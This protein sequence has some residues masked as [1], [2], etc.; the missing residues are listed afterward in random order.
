MSILRRFVVILCLMICCVVSLC[1]CGDDVEYSDNKYIKSCQE[2]DSDMLLLGNEYKEK[3]NTDAA[4]LIHAVASNVKWSYDEKNRL[5]CAET[6]KAEI[7]GTKHNVKVY[8]HP[9]SVWQQTSFHY[10]VYIDNINV[11]CIDFFGYAASV[12]LGEKDNKYKSTLVPRKPEEYAS[13]VKELLD[14]YTK[15]K[16]IDY[17]KYNLQSERPNITK[18]DAGKLEEETQELLDFA[19]RNG[20]NRLY[21]EKEY[22]NG[23]SE[24]KKAWIDGLTN[25]TERNGMRLMSNPE[26][27]VKALMEGSTYEVS[28]KYT[29]DR[30][31]EGMYDGVEITIAVNV[32][33]EEKMI[34][35]TNVLYDKMSKIKDKVKNAETRDVRIKIGSEGNI[36]LNDHFQNHLIWSDKTET[37]VVYIQNINLNKAELKEILSGLTKSICDNYFEVFKKGLDHFIGSKQ[38]KETGK[39]KHNEGYTIEFTPTGDTNKLQV[40]FHK[41]SGAENFIIVFYNDYFVVTECWGNADKSEIGQKQYY[42][43]N[44]GT[45][46]VKEAAIAKGWLKL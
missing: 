22:K 23:I 33:D 15:G 40:D 1:G 41:P 19:E 4:H 31:V 44:S 3:V 8:L 32:L 35:E 12:Y 5:V 13:F 20:L 2:F 36:I 21:G 39:V 38:N 37:V 16:E 25:G 45:N 24:I 6:D 17:S 7:Y 34:A 43:D 27:L 28:A 14:F 10:K 18:K 46:K 11:S 42:K 26:E 30:D 29:Q 9:R